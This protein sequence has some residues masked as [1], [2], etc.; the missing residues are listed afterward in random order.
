LLARFGL[1]EFQLWLADDG[2][3]ILVPTVPVK[4]EVIQ[5]RI[6]VNQHGMPLQVADGAEAVEDANSPPE[7][8]AEQNARAA[9]RA[10]WQKFID[11]VQFEYPDQRKPRHGGNNWVR[12]DLQ[13][14]V[15]TMTA[16]RYAPDKIGIFF[17]FKGEASRDAFDTLRA[18]REQLARETGLHLQWIEDGA[19]APQVAADESIDI[20]DPQTEQAQLEWFQRTANALLNAFRPR[21]TQFAGRTSTEA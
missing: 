16:Y 1:A 7:G 2:R 13:S 8:P 4:T 18:G 15:P 14:P 20:S 9:N 12:I 17:Q 10:F 19:R 11:Q 6:I 21:L 5:H 3:R